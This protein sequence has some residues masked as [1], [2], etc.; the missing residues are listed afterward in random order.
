MSILRYFN[1]RG[2][3]AGS[4]LLTILVDIPST[5]TILRLCSSPTNVDNI[6]SE[7]IGKCLHCL[8]V[9]L[10]L[11][12]Y[13]KSFKISKFQFL[14]DQVMIIPLCMYFL[15]L[16]ENPKTPA[17]IS[18]AFFFIYAAYLLISMIMNFYDIKA[19]PRS[20]VRK[21]RNKASDMIIE[22]DSEVPIYEINFYNQKIS[23]MH[24]GKYPIPRIVGVNPR[25]S[26]YTNFEIF[27][28]FIN[29]FNISEATN[30]ADCNKIF[31]YVMVRFNRIHE[32]FDDVNLVCSFFLF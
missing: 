4:T 7:T 10:P 17:N 20:L 5:F 29:S 13:M 9:V 26:A 16:I 28:Q 3:T 12:A 27:Q 31:A 11:V 15:Y 2:H 6:I 32:L 14:R 19:K 25:S 18:F 21:Q 1:L 24:E 23:E 8:G 30:M 22:F